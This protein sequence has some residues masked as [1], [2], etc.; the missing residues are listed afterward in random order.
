MEKKPL[1]GIKAAFRSLRSNKTLTNQEIEVLSTFADKFTTVSTHPGIVGQDVSEIAKEVNLHHHTHTCRKYGKECR[2][3]F[4]KL[5]SPET[6]IA[7]P[8]KGTTETKKK[9][10]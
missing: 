7:Q 8:V 3:G 9:Q 5:P 4:E 1:K 6:I 2:F 10:D